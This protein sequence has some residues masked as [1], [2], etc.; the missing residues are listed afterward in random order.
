MNDETKTVKLFWLG[1]VNGVLEIGFEFECDSVI[2]VHLDLKQTLQ[3]H[4]ALGEIRINQLEYKE[5]KVD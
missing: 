2:Q 4:K 1:C 3:L 5:E